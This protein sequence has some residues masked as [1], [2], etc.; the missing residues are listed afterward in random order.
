MTPV[1]WTEAARTDLREIHAYIARDSEAYAH[2][3]IDRIKKAVEN[4]RLFPDA[5]SI[6]PEHADGDLREIFVGNYRVIFRARREMQIL[7][8]IHAARRLG[9]LVS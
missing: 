8:V 6:V 4:A 1:V 2:R 5:A 9:D 7:N 3:F